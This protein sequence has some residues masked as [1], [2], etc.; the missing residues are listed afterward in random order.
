LKTEKQPIVNGL[1][2]KRKSQTNLGEVEDNRFQLFALKASFDIAWSE[3]WIYQK[4]F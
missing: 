3:P 4:T 2:P 1:L